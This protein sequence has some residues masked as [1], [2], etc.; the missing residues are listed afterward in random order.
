LY[1]KTH[2]LISPDGI[3]AYT[4][5]NQKKKEPTAKPSH[6]N[7]ELVSTI[8]RKQNWTVPAFGKKRKQMIEREKWRKRSESDKG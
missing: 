1:K 2:L 5:K 4:K 3:Q 8:P 6:V 7:L